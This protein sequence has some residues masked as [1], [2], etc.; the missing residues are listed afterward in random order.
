MPTPHFVEEKSLSLVDL[1]EII[2]NIEKR[3]TPDIVIAADGP[4][5]PTAKAYGLYH[6]KRE[7]YFGV[8]ALVEGKFD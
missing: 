7:N 1:K 2:H 4:L 3:I 6:P 8:Q 5:S